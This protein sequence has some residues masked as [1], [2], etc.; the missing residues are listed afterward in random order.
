MPHTSNFAAVRPSHLYC[1][2]S[3]GGAVFFATRV[4]KTKTILLEDTAEDTAE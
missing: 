2:I 3:E 1:C 4:V